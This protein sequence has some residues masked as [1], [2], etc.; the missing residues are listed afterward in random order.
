[1]VIDE[2]ILLKNTAVIKEYKAG[3]IIFSENSLPKYYFQIKSGLVKLNT[4]REDGSEFIHSLPSKGHCFAETFLWSDM[5]YC[6]NA[7]AVIDTIIIKVLKDDFMNMIDQNKDLMHNLLKHNAERM[8]YRHKML[9]TLS[10]N[11]PSHR[12]YKVLQFLKDYHQIIEPFKFL[13]PFSRQQIANLTGL[14]VE[15]VIRNVKKLEQEDLVRI[16]EGRIYL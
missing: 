15:T 5:P 14:R 6:I 9:A 16:S 1:M 13:V 11:N 12:I 8:F 2:E 7:E 10:I 3:Q 4:Y